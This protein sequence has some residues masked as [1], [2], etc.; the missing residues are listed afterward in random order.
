MK[1]LKK[2]LLRLIILS[3]FGVVIIPAVYLAERYEHKATYLVNDKSVDDNNTLKFNKDA[4]V[5]LK[6]PIMNKYAKSH[7]IDLRNTLGLLQEMVKEGNK[8]V[9]LVI[10]SGG[11]IVDHHSYA[12]INYLKFLPTIGVRVNCVVDGFAASMALAVYTACS[13][14]FATPKSAILWHSIA[15]T[16]KMRVNAESINKLV[17]WVE[18]AN[19]H[20]LADLKVFFYPW[21]FM[22]HFRKESALPVG[23]IVKHSFGF[24]RIVNAMEHDWPLVVDKRTKPRRTIEFKIGKTVKITKP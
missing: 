24:L 15:R 3:T 6:G 19:S 5:W 11:G 21:Y 16:G 22:E 9:T 17:D 4:T 10:N 23:E 12:L 7:E 1:L 13:H 2:W 14:R 18:A 8:E 20:L